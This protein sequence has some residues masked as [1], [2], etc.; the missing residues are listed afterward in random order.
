MEKEF[1]KESDSFNTKEEALNHLESFK[2]EITDVGDIELQKVNSNND[3]IEFE[4]LAKINYDS[5]N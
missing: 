5:I 2:N 4:T 1:E 3:I